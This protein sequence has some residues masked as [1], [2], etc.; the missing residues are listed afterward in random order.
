MKLSRSRLYSSLAVLV[1]TLVTLLAA[2]PVA[3]AAPAPL[4]VAG[5]PSRA[6]MASN[7]GRASLASNVATPEDK[8][9]VGWD[10]YRRLDLLPFFRRGVQTRQFSSFDR[11]GGNGDFNTCLR[12][13][14]D[15]AC[16]L[17]EATGPGEIDSI[18]LTNIANNDAGNVSGVGY[19]NIQLDGQTVISASLQDVV[20]GKL[21]P[22]FVYPL[23]ANADQ[24]SGGD[25]IVVPMPYRQHMLVTTQYNHNPNYYHVTYR[26]FADA[27]GVTTFNPS[28]DNGADVIATLRAAGTADPK[29]ARSNAV[30]TT[31]PFSVAAGGSLTFDPVQGPGEIT[32]LRLQLPRIVGPQPTVPITDD[33]RAFGRDNTT[34]SQFTVKIDPN[35]NGVR[36]TRRLDNEVGHQRA[37][38]YVDGTDVGISWPGSPAAPQPQVANQSVKLRLH[39]AYATVHPAATVAAPPYFENQSVELPAAATHGKTQITIKNV[40]ISSDN[41]FN[42]F[43]YWVDSHVTVSGT[44]TLARTDTLDVGPDHTADETAHHYTIVGQTFAGVRTFSYAPS[45]QQQQT[46]AASSEV[47]RDT[48]LRIS[49]DGQQT[50]DSPLDEFFGSSF[51][52][53]QVRS[54]FTAIDLDPNGYFS[55]WWP[56]PYR[57]SATI[58]LV[59]NSTTPITGGQLLVTSALS[60]TWATALDPDTGDAG[61]FRTTS[62]AGPTTPGQ[63][64]SFLDA[65]GEGTFVGVTHGMS[66]PSSRVYLEGDERAY[67]DGSRSPQIHGT[68]TEDFYEGGWYFDRDMF[69]DPFNG[70]P[71]HQPGTYG[72]PGDC[73]ST[74]R[75]MIADA[76]P[77]NAAL[78][79]GIEH[80]PVDDVPATYS[81]TAYWYGQDRYAL[82]T[83]DTL[84]VGATASEAA[85]GYTS[86][87]AGTPYTLTDTFE[88]NDG[89]P[90]PVTA[91]GLATTA[92]LTFTLSIDPNNGGILLR[93][94][95]DQANAY[96]AA[97]VYVNG[98]DAG[99]WL[100]PLGNAFHRWLDDSFELPAALTAGQVTA[101]IELIPQPGAPPWNAA[102]YTALSHVR[103]FSDQ[104]PPSQVT[105]LTAQGASTN[106]ITLSW[107][108]ASDNV[109]VDH[110]NVYGSTDPAFVDGPMTLIAQTTA[111][112]FTHQNLGLNQ[113]WYYRVAAVDGA[114]NVG[115]DSA[116]ASATTGSTLHIEAESLLP[117]ITSTAPAV[118][119]GNCCGVTWSNNQQ[120]WF[121]SHAVGDDVT[122]AFTVPTSGAYDLSAVL[123]KAP[124][125]GINTLSIDGHAVGQPFDGYN[126]NGVTTA[127]VDDGQVALAAGQH[128]LTLT[129]TGKN[130]SAAG[131]F[132]GIDYLELRLLEAPGTPTATVT[133][134]TVPSATV[135]VTG[136]TVPSAT[137]SATV[138]ATATTAS[139]TAGT[140]VQPTETATVSATS[141][142]TATPTTTGTSAP[143][144]STNTAVPPTATATSTAVPATATNTAVPP[145]ATSTAAPPTM[146]STA[147]P[148]PAT[149]TNTAVPP[150]ST[151]T[152]VPPTAT[153]TAVLPT[154]TSTA[155]PPT[156]TSMPTAPPVCQLFALPAF[157]TV[158]RGGNQALLIDAAPGSAITLTV[159]AKYPASATL[160]TDSSLAGDS[161]GRDLRGARVS[162]GYRYAFRVAASGLALLT[163][164][165]PHDAR[166][167]TVIIQAAAQEPCGL[168]KTVTT[169]QV[170]GTVR[171]GGAARAPGRAV[172][173]A[174]PLPRGDTPPAN[175]SQLARRG[176]LRV[177]TRGHGATARRILLLTYHPRSAPASVKASATHPRSRPARAVKA[178]A[179]HP[180][181]HTLFG[182]AVDARGAGR[183]SS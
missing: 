153:S 160:Y 13:T 148:V 156:S 151:G 125:Y 119:Q 97:E 17:A 65:Q 159:R 95:S 99:L 6:S 102:R 163:F 174:I 171:G 77:F 78:R 64:W 33:G 172:T 166:Q 8:G 37:E 155:V 118:A 121:Q 94:M 67:A 30:T 138:T 143:A 15:N 35:N 85:H 180:R 36:L 31:T 58:T 116:Q 9:P 52:R 47:L 34:Y 168:F 134:T 69:T 7:A 161:F 147:T 12:T 135:T 72:C 176:I 149:A 106:E 81:S 108:P 87:D 139:P 154:S 50:V 152:A 165:I 124:D 183:A 93:R 5:L 181:P 179:A 123:T 113:T 62:H 170:R 130:P 41:D 70:N 112:G 127:L 68:G 24:S 63:D 32:A 109:G 182:V 146:T 114:G 126:G 76:V 92:P 23:V 56:M 42:E 48:R 164:A 103:P 115:P 61:Y 110:Y 141:T 71:A 27:N 10:V 88:G 133:G 66:G 57:Q 59:N 3:S 83:T 129:I 2:L 144:T 1:T 162:G 128:T 46:V 40:F 91:A 178:R 150:T 74:Y 100:E 73:T 55:S 111:T 45:M 158:P 167:G 26:R 19:I 142:A 173:L 177:M 22:P 51:G 101:T 98:T 18:W 53:Y 60:N 39:G 96:Q 175:T 157:D 44:D 21:G 105:G 38:L 25:Y 131:Y 16:V 11:S 145:T 132:A 120:L 4:R 75:L 43:Y 20:D 169:F 28:A 54:L 80:G 14:S 86:P 104:Q 107:Q 89:P 136:T 90:Q 29:P 84:D 137:A 140:T 82:R 79:F 122:L 117:P 49:F